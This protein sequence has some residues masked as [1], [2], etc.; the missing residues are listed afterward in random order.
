MV[1]TYKVN[2]NICRLNSYA[3]TKR[4]QI[5]P[6]RTSPASE[7]STRNKACPRS[8]CHQPVPRALQTKLLLV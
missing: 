1:I 8:P 5:L 4:F 2:A 3:D 7:G 6:S